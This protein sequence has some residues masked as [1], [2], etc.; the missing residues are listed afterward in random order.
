MIKIVQIQMILMLNSVA[1]PVFSQYPIVFSLTKIVVE[2]N[3]FFYLRQ[4]QAS[5]FTKGKGF[6]HMP[7]IPAIA[8]SSQSNYSHSNSN[9][10]D[11]WKLSKK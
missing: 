2:R 1:V 5:R 7:V 6:K 9:Q 11:Q 10:F 4:K 8:L 3:F